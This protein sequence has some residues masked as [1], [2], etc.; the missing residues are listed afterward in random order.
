MSRLV[1]IE[2]KR[3]EKLL[4]KLGFI[5]VRQKGSHAAYRH[6]DGRMTTIPFHTGKAIPRPL[7]REILR[8]I[9]LSIDEYNE[10][11]GEI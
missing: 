10:K 9:G 2:A 4:F 11:I 5:K 6:G 8:E 1:L 3:L 7:L